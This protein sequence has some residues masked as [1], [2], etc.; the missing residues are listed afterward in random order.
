MKGKE[1]C[2]ARGARARGVT[3]FEVLIVVAIIA[4]ISSG[5]GFAALHMW[6]RAQIEQAHTDGRA[7]LAG[8][9]GYWYVHRDTNRCP[10]FD[11]LVRDKVVRRD[12]KGR[13]P[14]GESWRIE[15]TEGEAF[16]SSSGPDRKAGTDDDIRIP[17]V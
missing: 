13:D 6:R 15:C 4:L 12:S 3:L 11:E 1:V 7:V 9:D 5:V 8:V 16:V 14:W 2:P 17:P 10:S